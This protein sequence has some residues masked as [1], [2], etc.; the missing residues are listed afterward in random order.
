MI[1]SVTN[2]A[3]TSNSHMKN[4]S[5][6]LSGIAQRMRKVCKGFLGLGCDKS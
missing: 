5:I 6:G 1:K 4:S 2:H 3:K